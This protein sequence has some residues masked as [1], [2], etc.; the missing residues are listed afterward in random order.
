MIVVP[1]ET[2]GTAAPVAI[3][4]IVEIVEI[5]ARVSRVAIVPSVLL[6]RPVRSVLLPSCRRVTGRST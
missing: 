6:A 5:V 2:V 4:A 3:V 1:V